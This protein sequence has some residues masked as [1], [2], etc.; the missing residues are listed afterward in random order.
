MR[1]SPCIPRPREAWSANPRRA[2]PLAYRFE[3]I[4]PGPAIQAI[5]WYTSCVIHLRRNPPINPVQ[6]GRLPRANLMS[7]QKPSVGNGIQS[8]SGSWSF[9]KISDEFT[10]HIAQSIPLYDENLGLILE[11]S[12]FFT[13]TGGVIYDLGCSTGNFL[14]SLAARNKEK[15]GLRFIG[16]DRVPDMIEHAQSQEPDDP[17][18]EFTHADITQE[19]FLPD[20]Q[21]ISSLYTMQFIHPKNRQTLFDK[22]YESLNWGGAFFLTEKVRSADARFQDYQT[23]VYNEYK[24]KAG[25]KAEEVLAKQSALKG[26]MEPFSDRANREMLERAGFQDVTTIFKWLCFET[27]LAVK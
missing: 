6:S 11:Y 22:I 16:F 7:H 10:A 20:V 13:G 1:D 15:E 14:R 8:D 25:F 21:M 23:T 12:D 24:I 19:S 2:G 18:I 17:R 5:H 27:F 9:S 3:G 26:V 4:T